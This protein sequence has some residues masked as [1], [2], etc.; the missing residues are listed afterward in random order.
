MS[1]FNSSLYKD[2]TAGMPYGLS[3][4][5]RRVP[6]RGR[7]QRIQLIDG[8]GCHISYHFHYSAILYLKL[9][10]QVKL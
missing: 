1:P 8:V 2:S 5:L 6:T 10:L 3:Q 4:D 7:D 9:T